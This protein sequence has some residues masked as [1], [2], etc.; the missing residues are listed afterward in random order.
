M[1][2][3]MEWVDPLG[4]TGCKNKKTTYEAESRKDALRQAK[5]DA[6]VPMSQQPK[7]E[8]VDL[9]NGYGEKVLDK[10]G[11]PVRAREY[12]YTNMNGEHVVIQEHSLGHTKV[13]PLHGLE[14][15]F[16]VRQV[17]Q[18][19]GEVLNT[20]NFPGTHGHYNF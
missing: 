14:P 7:V 10:N 5:R 18:H 8:H 16:N 15:H 6:G 12:H 17:D 2:N 11:L 4:L 13:T 9:L 19:T 1:H 3:P 20:S